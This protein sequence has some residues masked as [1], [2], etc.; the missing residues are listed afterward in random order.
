MYHWQLLSSYFADTISFYKSNKTYPKESKWNIF[1]YTKMWLC[2]TL[3]LN[4]LFVSHQFI[5]FKSRFFWA[6][7]KWRRR[8]QDVWNWT[9]IKYLYVSWCQYCITKMSISIPCFLSAFSKFHF[10]VIFFQTIPGGDVI[11]D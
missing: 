2:K 8:Q 10:S 5:F 6:W 4:V 9:K 7:E 3:A 11:C 1:F